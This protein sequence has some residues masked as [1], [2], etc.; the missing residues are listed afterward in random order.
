MNMR[1]FLTTTLAVFVFVFISQ[2]IIDSYI[3]VKL[4][5]ATAPIW[6]NFKE[7]LLNLPL[8]LC[9]MFV[10]SAWTT[11]VFY[12]ICPEGGLRNGLCFGFYF[13]ILIGLFAAS[14]YLWLPVPPMLALG[15]FITRF[16]QILISGAILGVLSIKR[17]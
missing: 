11:I 1:R 6:R 17:E 7:M 10:L 9:F 15:W 13:G 3:L 14:W 8:T 12:R 2:W 16:L 4:Y 5:V